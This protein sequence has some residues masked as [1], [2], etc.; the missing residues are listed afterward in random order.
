MS[1]ERIPVCFL[2]QFFIFD[3][4]LPAYSYKGEAFGSVVL[5]CT[6]E[7]RRENGFARIFSAPRDVPQSM[8]RFRKVGPSSFLLLA[9]VV[10]SVGVLQAFR[11]LEV[12]LNSPQANTATEGST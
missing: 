12:H 1:K 9:S 2:S 11:S 4:I 10:A 5:D 8:A 7:A 3:T 6:W